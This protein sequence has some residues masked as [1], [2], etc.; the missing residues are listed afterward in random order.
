MKINPYFICLIVV[1]II[2]FIFR[3]L[4]TPITS[5]TPA[6]ITSTSKLSNFCVTEGIDESK[7]YN[8]LD[9]LLENEEKKATQKKS[10]LESKLNGLESNSLRKYY[11]L[12]LSL[13][14]I[15]EPTRPY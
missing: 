15:S 2:L 6:S 1:P 14:H 13:I 7:C 3:E 10:S 12:D 11:A 5:S 8:N 4:K 9:F